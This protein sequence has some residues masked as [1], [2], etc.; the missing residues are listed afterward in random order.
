MLKTWVTIPALTRPRNPGE[1]DE[2]GPYYV[3]G[4]L[5]PGTLWLCH[6]KGI[7]QN[8]YGNPPSATPRWW[9]GSLHRKER[10]IFGSGSHF[11]GPWSLL[12]LPVSIPGFFQPGTI[13]VPW[14]RAHFKD[15]Q[16]FPQLLSCGCLHIS[17]LHYPCSQQESDQKLWTSSESTQ[18]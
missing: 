1:K 15:R 10:F 11:R 12:P 17:A 18:I 4:W 2:M 13:P 16:D 8:Q 6:L 5:T 7:I 14:M 9:L 3:C